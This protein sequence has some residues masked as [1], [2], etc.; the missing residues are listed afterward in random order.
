MARRSHRR[1]LGIIGRWM[2]ETSHKTGSVNPR[3]HVEYILQVNQN[4]NDGGIRSDL[5]G[6]SWQCQ[7]PDGGVTMC[8]E[9]NFLNPDPND[10]F[11]AGPNVHH[12]VPAKDKR[13]CPWGTNSYTNAAVISR[14]LNIFLS[15]NNPT[16]QEV[17][18]LNNAGAYP[19]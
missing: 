16:V 15:N 8:I 9:P 19:P 13:C 14:T 11:G 3:R 7:D 18:Q 6:Y 1:Q 17:T 2:Y 4:A 12:V 5:H 10:P